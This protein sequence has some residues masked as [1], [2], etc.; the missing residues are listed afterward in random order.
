VRQALKQLRREG[1]IIKQGKRFI[2]ND[3]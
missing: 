3:R 1:F 2:I